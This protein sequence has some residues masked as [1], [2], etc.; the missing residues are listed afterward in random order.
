MLDTNGLNRKTELMTGRYG[1]EV[2][3]LGVRVESRICGLVERTVVSQSFKNNEFEAIEV[4]YTFPLPPDAAVCGFEVITGDR[5]LTGKAKK[6]DEAVKEYD[7]AIMEGDGAYMLESHRRDV[8]TVNIGNINPG[9]ISVLRIDY[10]RT[11]SFADG[12]LSLHY[13]TTVPYRYVTHTGVINSEAVANDAEMINPIRD[14]NVPYGLVLDLM[15]DSGFY[16]SNAT[17]PTHELLVVPEKSRDG[18]VQN[19]VSLLDGKVAMDR[20]VV[21]ELSFDNSETPESYIEKWNKKHYAAI[22]F[23]PD[24]SALE[25]DEPPQTDIVFVLDCSGSMRGQSIDQAKSALML[26]LRSLRVGDTFNIIRFGSNYELFADS[27]TQYNQ[28]TLEEAQA[29]VDLSDASLGGTELIKP[30]SAVFGMQAQQKIDVVVL[31]DGQIS[32]DLTAINLAGQHANTHRIFSF[33][34]GSAVGRNLCV[35]LAEKTQGAA[36]FISH[37]ERIDEKVLRTFCRIV[38]PVLSNV[39]LESADDQRLVMSQNTM[40]ALFDGDAICLLACVEGEMPDSDQ[41][42]TLRAEYLGV[43]L[44]WPIFAKAPVEIQYL[45]DSSIAVAWANERIRALESKLK[46]YAGVEFAEP[47]TTKDKNQKR[48]KQHVISLSTEFNVLCDQ[49]AFVA[50]EHRS[51]AERNDGVPAQREIPVMMPNEASVLMPNREPVIEPYS[52]FCNLEIPSRSDALRTRKFDM[53]DEMA[54]KSSTGVEH[55]IG[56]MDRLYIPAFLRRQ[57]N[58]IDEVE[59]NVRKS[60]LEPND[61]SSTG[62]NDKELLNSKD[63]L[64]ALLQAQQSDGRFASV[65]IFQEIRS[66]LMQ[67]LFTCNE[68]DLTKISEDDKPAVIDTVL[69]VLVLHCIYLNDQSLWK[70]ADKK[71]HAYLKKHGISK[72]AIRA[73]ISVGLVT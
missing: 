42:W 24:F 58:D 20:D 62:S 14:V 30:L 31:T 37:Y 1:E 54:I 9:Q 52:D 39:V 56:F 46:N 67:V 16:L 25:I 10:V 53:P 44:S 26:C 29:W 60:S 22:S 57:A 49:T 18:T 19:R 47:V 41:R 70:R 38:S 71:A 21:L 69:A 59:S 27:M 65:D 4:T 63:N 28:Q 7:E 32:N 43:E 15:I 72:A 35:G 66:D 64:F 73:V 50:T 12:Q 34:I 33:G 40:P 11:L 5:V 8:F 68:I 61:F 45:A 13:P 2:A 48:V 3:L 6:R 23:L 55:K 17:S 36:E 51:L